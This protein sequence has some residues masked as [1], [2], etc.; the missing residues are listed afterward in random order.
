MNTTSAI[1]TANTMNQA[2]YVTETELRDL[3]DAGAT[4]QQLEAVI[5]RLPCDLRQFS[6]RLADLHGNTEAEAS[7]AIQK[8]IQAC[9]RP[10][11]TIGDDFAALIDQTLT[12]H[13]QARPGT[14]QEDRAFLLGDL[15]EAIDADDEAG[16]SVAIAMSP[17]DSGDF[18][19]HLIE[20]VDAMPQDMLIQPEQF[21]A[22]QR[23]AIVAAGVP[24]AVLDDELV[25]AILAAIER[26][27]TLR[28]ETPHQRAVRVAFKEARALVDLHGEDD[29]RAFAAIVR[30]VNLNEPGF[31]DAKLKECGIHLPAPDRCTD[32][33]VPLY[34]LDAIA[35]ALDADP[36]ELLVKARELE[37]LGT[38]DVV[39]VAGDNTHTLQ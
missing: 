11:C 25:G 7:Q 20:A 26:L 6:D 39:R 30:A 4:L 29:P 38:G 5:P 28:E 31:V 15:R 23:A 3:L 32:D 10:G 13:A 9:A 8:A 35:K 33:G 19:R 24:G 14:H 12:G 37:M 34:S 22:M 21:E 17:F 1:A 16:L 36:E 2:A 18:Y 27:R